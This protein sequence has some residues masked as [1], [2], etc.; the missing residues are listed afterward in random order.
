MCSRLN[1]CTVNILDNPSKIETP[2]KVEITFEVFEYLKDEVEWE[3]VFVANDGKEERDQLLD[4]VVIG[5]IRD[6]RHKFVFE[7]PAPDMEK[8]NN[9]DLT[10]VTV[11]LLRCKYR[12]QMFVKIAW[13]VS[14]EYTDPELIAT[15]P[16]KPIIEKL[17][18]NVSTEDVRVTYYA[19]KW[20]DPVMDD[21]E[22]QGEQALEPEQNQT[23]IAQEPMDANVENVNPISQQKDIT[24][25]GTEQ[26]MAVD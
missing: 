11:L 13:F 18:R 1:I 4:S 10:D 6:G 16:D 14:H 3:L 5:P 9:E 20:D 17:Q 25:A 8:L 26:S 12:E 2:F 24:E 15:P 21:E 19:I 22:N 7:A 23:E